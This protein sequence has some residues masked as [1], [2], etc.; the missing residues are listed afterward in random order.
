MPDYMVKIIGHIDVHRRPQ[1]F[2]E[3]AIQV[4]VVQNVDKAGLLDFVV[5]RTREIIYLQGMITSLDP[6][7]LIDPEK[8]D[9]N[10]AFVPMHMLTHLSSE[11]AQLVQPQSDLPDDADIDA[12]LTGKKPS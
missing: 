9:T 10:R 7:A 4:H 3:N 1:G 11:V 2:P 5:K 6:A 8:I 12:A